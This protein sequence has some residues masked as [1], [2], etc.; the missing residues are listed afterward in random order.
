MSASA[1]AIDRTHHRVTWKPTRPD[2]T[3][4]TLHGTSTSRGY[5]ETDYEVISRFPLGAQEFKH[6]DA[7]GLLGIGQAYTP[8]PVETIVDSVPAVTIDQ[9]TGEVLPDV[10][11]VNWQGQAITTKH[12][13][14]YYRYV[15]RRICDS[16]D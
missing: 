15:V 10:A 8:G 16:G 5:H 14:T 12:D 4:T 2:L 9:R 7:C 13:Y 6:L 11:P 1:P 3:I